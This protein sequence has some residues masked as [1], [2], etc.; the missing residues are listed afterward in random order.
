[1]YF[2][3][4]TEPRDRFPETVGEADMKYQYEMLKYD[5]AQEYNK[6]RNQGYL[7]SKSE[8]YANYFKY[9]TDYVKGYTFFEYNEGGENLKR[10]I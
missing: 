6:K 9:I 5:R 8:Y 1:M 10:H 2:S 4:F 3:E 7:D